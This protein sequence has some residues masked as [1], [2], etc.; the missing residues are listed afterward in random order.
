MAAA[1]QFHGDA[2]TQSEDAMAQAMVQPAG[3][4]VGAL[5]PASDGQAGVLRAVVLAVLGSAL[6]AGF[7][8]ISVPF[9]PVPL[10]MQT[11]AVLA[12]GITYGAR[13]G[14]A[15][16]I[17]YLLE[18]FAGLPVFAGGNSGP[19]YMSGPTGG[20]LVGFVFAAG[21]VGRLA[22][23]GWDRSPLRT[24]GAMVLGNLTIYLFGV[25]WLTQFL[26]SRQTLDLSAGF[27]RAMAGG[28]YPFLLGDALKVLLA[29]A[30][31]W[32]AWQAIDKRRR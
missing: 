16:V 10:T 19:V 20:F 12:I 29:T 14:A 23:D 8:Q 7:A 2:V 31:L 24:V 9:W 30:M 13:L 22:E 5:W 28:V 3:G 15:T 6:L 4:L 1:R 21:I 32:S 26:A 25:A 18:G 17:L 27:M 11:F